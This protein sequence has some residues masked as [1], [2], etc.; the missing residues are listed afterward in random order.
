MKSSL[1]CLWLSSYLC[2]VVG[3]SKPA[4]GDPAT[5]GA[6]TKSPSTPHPTAMNDHGEPHVLT[7]MDLAGLAFEVVQEG[8]IVAGKEGA[9]D[10]VFAA[11]TKLPAVARV[12]LGT[13]SGE[14]SRKQKLGKEGDRTLHGHIDV[15][16]PIP[17][18]SKLWLEFEV[19]GKPLRIS[20]DWHR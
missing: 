19:D 2:L 7:K 13:E 12:W 11:G 14:G 3:C 15:P 5:A 18:G 9:V 4:P 8:P 1:S 17:A 10:V 16:D 20:T 6:G